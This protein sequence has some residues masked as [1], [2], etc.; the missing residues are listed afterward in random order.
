MKVE[1]PWG[2]EIIWAN[3]KHYIAKILYIEAGH[4]L[5]KQYH[6]N[7]TETVYVIDG[8][9][10][11]YD[12]NDNIQKFLPGESFHVSP[13]QIHRFSAR[14]SS[15][16]LIEVSTPQLDDVIRIEDDYNRN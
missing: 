1:K 4:R 2:Y 13:H 3:T 16:T 7:K 11:N 9:L 8:V 15:V 5:S 12:F 6:Q 14:D 10:Y